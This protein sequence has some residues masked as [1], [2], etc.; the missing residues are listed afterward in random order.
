MTATTQK[1]SKTI[2]IAIPVFILIQTAAV[3]ISIAISS[4]MFVTWMIL[5]LVQFIIDRQQAISV[6]TLPDLKWINIFV[7]LYFLA[8]V[9]SRIFAVYPEGAFDNIKRLLLFAIF[10]ASVGKI[11]GTL[12]MSKMLIALISLSSVI[13]AIELTTYA[14]SFGEMIA[15]MQFSEIRI[16]YFNYPLTIAEIKM[17]TLLSVFPLLFQ[18]TDFP[19]SRK[20]MILLCLPVIVSMLLTQSRNVYLAF[21]ICM[22]LYGIVMNRRFLVV[23]LVA[24]PVGYL[25]LP[26]GV[27]QRLT[28]IFDASHPSNKSRI[29]MWETGIKMFADHPITGVADN[30][31]LEIYSEYKTP[32]YH[33]EGVHLHSN[34]IMILATTGLLGFTAFIGLFAALILKQFKLMRQFGE[35]SKKLLAFGSILVVISFLISGI[36]EWSFGDHEVM[37]AFFFL[38]SVPFITA[39]EEFIAKSNELLSS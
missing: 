12:L 13:S 24:V 14:V 27:T 11:T 21:F 29:A 36:F 25:M 32:E 8:E 35:G 16:D 6:F 38:V 34:F 33:S 2:D 5:W 3:G 28:S 19:L 22:V 7:L 4:I 17:M 10:Y 37:T 18:S 15:K 23:L 39:K 20:Y 1:L 26:A 30:K 9:I 31:I